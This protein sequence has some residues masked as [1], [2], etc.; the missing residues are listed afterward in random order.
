MYL[1]IMVLISE[2]PMGERIDNELLYADI[3]WRLFSQNTRAELPYAV[4]NLALA[5]QQNICVPSATEAALRTHRMQKG[6][7]SSAQ[8]HRDSKADAAHLPLPFP[9]TYWC[10]MPFPSV[11][12]PG[13]GNGGL[14]W[15]FPVLVGCSPA[16]P[17]VGDPALWGLTLRQ[18]GWE[19]GQLQGALSNTDTRFYAP[20]NTSAAKTVFHLA[21]GMRRKGRTGL[22]CLCAHA[23]V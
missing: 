10:F 2:D 16:Q 22:C 9:A 17:S 1:N 3:K 23:A 20:L 12:R 6:H 4:T 21:K 7:H 19:G 18:A 13:G 11:T 15:T 5:Q 8:Q 14:S